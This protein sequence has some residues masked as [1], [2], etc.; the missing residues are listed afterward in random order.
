MN[1]SENDAILKIPRLHSLAVACELIPMP[2]MAALYQFLGKHKLEL[3]THRFSYRRTASGTHCRDQRFL[4]DEEI[5]KIRE[6]TFKATTHAH[7]GRPRRA[8][9]PIEAIMMRAMQR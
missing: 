5:L 6:M 3:P 9:N 2:S 8:S 4:T 7:P 1:D